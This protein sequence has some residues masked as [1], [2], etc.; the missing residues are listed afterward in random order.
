MLRA[1]LGISQIRFDGTHDPPASD[2][3]IRRAGTPIRGGLLE[4]LEVAG[5]PD[6]VAVAG[7]R[8]RTVVG[9]LQHQEQEEDYGDADENDHGSNLSII[10]LLPTV[11]DLSWYI[12]FLPLC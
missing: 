10:R 11:A 9:R 7:P 1:G 2:P 6:I 5:D 4:E 8:G 12:T 3:W